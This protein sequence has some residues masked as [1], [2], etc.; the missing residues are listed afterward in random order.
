MSNEPIDAIITWVDGNDPKLKAKQ[1]QYFT[2]AKNDDTQSSS[3]F[4]DTGELYYCI[5]SILKFAPF[6]RNI[7]IVTDDQYPHAHLAR[8]KNRF[9]EEVME[10]IKIV[11]HRE[12]FRGYENHLPTF[13]SISI[14][15][16]LFRVPG[17]AKN[18]VYFNDD[19]FIA[20]PLTPE[21]FFQNNRP[22]IY[23]SWKSSFLPRLTKKIRQTNFLQRLG[24]KLRKLSYKET[25]CFSF[26]TLGIKSQYLQFDHCPHPF[27]RETV[28]DFFVENSDLLEKNIIYK[29]RSEKQFYLMAISNGL[30]VLKGKV[31]TFPISLV[32][33]KI[34]AKQKQL[35]YVKRKQKELLAKNP[36]FLCVQELVTASPAAQAAAIKWLDELI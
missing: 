2:P 25:Q 18:C 29:T 12:I 26:A 31:E 1:A 4:V 7:F 23:A 28:D 20:R 21:D 9:G 19:M 10:Q 33:L 32:Y 11:D 8:I 14:E 3:R 17:A 30:E 6:I 5:S 35:E 22:V 36:K 24:I 15:T 34:S 13:N 16:M 27:C